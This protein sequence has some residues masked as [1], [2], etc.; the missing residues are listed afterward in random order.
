M[1]DNIIST[2]SRFLTPEVLGKIASASGLDTSVA[3]K[4]VAAAVPAI[5]SGLAEVAG[6]AGGAQKIAH[7]VAEQPSDILGRLAGALSGSAQITDKGTSLLSSLLGGGALGMLAS[8]VSKFMGI[9]E[10]ATRTLMGLLTPVIL[11]VLGREQ[12]T[13]GLDANGLARMLTGQKHEII[14]AMP[15]GLSGLLEASGLYHGN[16]APSPSERRTYD[17]PRTAYVSPRTGSVQRMVSDAKASA[18][19]ASWPYWV[20]PLLALGGLLL[21]MLPSA[22]Q[23]AEPLRTSQPAT[24]PMRSAEAKTLYLASVP[25]NWVSSN[26][27][28]N[29]EVYNRAGEKLGVIRELLIGPDGRTAAA[30]VNVGRYL[31]IGDKDIVVPFT[32]LQSEG[33]RIVIDAT[34]EGLQA[35]PSYERRA[36]KQ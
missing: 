10:G 22:R 3:Q 2:I 35:A 28:V 5:L 16:D 27:Y 24:Q 30:V 4:A 32:A 21:Y 25:D 12:R 19:G 18:Q 6:K 11:G 29:Q 34:K 20:L 31:G 9:G 7:A 33:R 1:T 23:P 17:P 15:A 26:G 8:T 13:N 14:D 36:P